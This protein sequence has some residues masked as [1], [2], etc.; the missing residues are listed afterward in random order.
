[1]ACAVG[2]REVVITATKAEVSG[3][4]TSARCRSKPFASVRAAPETSLRIAS[5]LGPPFADEAAQRGQ[6]TGPGS[7]SPKMTEPGI[8]L[9]P[10]TAKSVLFFKSVHSSTAYVK[11][12]AK[13]QKGGPLGGGMEADTQCQAEP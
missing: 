2:L 8:R 7:H 13:A 12:A 4:L 10:P 3:E 1:M 5:I 11:T 9:R 6:L